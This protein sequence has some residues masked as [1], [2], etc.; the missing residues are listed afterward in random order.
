VWSLTSTPAY[1]F[2]AQEQIY[3]YLLHVWRRHKN[4]TLFFSHFPS[5]FCICSCLSPL[6]FIFLLFLIL[7]FPTFSYLFFFFFFFIS[8]NITRTIARS[9]FLACVCVCRERTKVMNLT[10]TD[11]ICR[12]LYSTGLIKFCPLWTRVC[13]CV[14]FNVLLTPLWVISCSA[15]RY[16]NCIQ[17]TEC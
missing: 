16:I 11:L 4:A 1:V 7:F 9:V 2:M 3:L 17:C 13:V 14:L 12:S 10:C 15:K 5:T 6:I 8:L